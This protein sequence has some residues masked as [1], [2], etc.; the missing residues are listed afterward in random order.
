VRVVREPRLPRVRAAPV[1]R[2]VVAPEEGAAAGERRRA[3]RPREQVLRRQATPGRER[4]SP[5]RVPARAHPRVDGPLVRA[6]DRKQFLHRVR[7]EGVHEEGELRV[8]E[9][10]AQA[11]RQEQADRHHIL[12][13]PRARAVVEELELERQE[14]SALA[15][16]VRVH[17]CHVR[18]HDGARRVP[19]VRVRRE[20]GG[21]GPE[22]D[23]AVERVDLDDVHAANLRA[24][25][26]REL[27]L[28]DAAHEVHLREAV[29]RMD[30]ALGEEEVV[31]RGR[32]DVRDPVEVAVDGHRAVEAGVRDLEALR[33]LRLLRDGPDAAAGIREAPEGRED[34]EGHRQDDDEQDGDDHGREP[35]GGDATLHGTAL[36]PHPWRR[37]NRFRRLTAGGQRLADHGHRSADHGRSLADRGR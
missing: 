8:L 4:K 1:D 3:L 10:A 35:F 32:E 25:D 30:E 14:G 33:V 29:L 15:V 23:R 22:P 24:E 6:V 27:A 34:A 36:D 2:P 9:R 20:V 16:E 28:R 7:A 12:R 13:G 21:E 37:R 11:P 17:T 18:L 5:V 31:L 19:R 26:L